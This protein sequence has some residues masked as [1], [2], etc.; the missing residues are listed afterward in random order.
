MGQTTTTHGR[1]FTRVMKPEPQ[2]DITQGTNF[3]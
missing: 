3:W 2:I 1:G